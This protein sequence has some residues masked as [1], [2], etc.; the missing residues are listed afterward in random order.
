MGKKASEKEPHV[1]D[2]R[3]TLTTTNLDS[4]KNEQLIWCRIVADCITESADTLS[5][6]KYKTF[7][8]EKMNDRTFINPLGLAMENLQVDDVNFSN[9][10]KVKFPAIVYYETYLKLANEETKENMKKPRKEIM[11]V[12]I[13]YDSNRYKELSCKLKI[14]KEKQEKEERKLNEE[15]EKVKRQCEREEELQ[16]HG[17]DLNEI[18]ELKEFIRDKF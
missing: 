13:D 9:I 11:S 4:R 16:L 14:T 10:F 3:W 6:I 2:Y 5:I 12:K 18:E 1:V 17:F 15:L 8:S 7:A